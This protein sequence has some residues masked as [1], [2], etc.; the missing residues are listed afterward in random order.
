LAVMPLAKVTD[1]TY[2]RSPL[3]RLLGYGT[4]IMESAGQDQALSRVDFL[5]SPDQ[6][7]QRLSQELFGPDQREDG[8]DPRHGRYG[9]TQPAAATA[10]TSA[11]PPSPTS[12]LPRLF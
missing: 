5:R 9:P 3:G 6:L 2:E 8:D 1:L 12:R 7:Y 10:D 4:F 11:P